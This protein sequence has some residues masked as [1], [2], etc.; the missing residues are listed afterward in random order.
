MLAK[1]TSFLLGFAFTSP[2]ESVAKV[3]KMRISWGD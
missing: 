1:K 3:E 2:G